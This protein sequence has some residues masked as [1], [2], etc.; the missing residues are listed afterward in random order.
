VLAE[1]HYVASDTLRVLAERGG[2][3]PTQK[4]I[5]TDGIYNHDICTKPR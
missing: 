2:L 5:G 3:F 1:K 4:T